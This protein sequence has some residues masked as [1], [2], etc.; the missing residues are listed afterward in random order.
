MKRIIFSF[1]A[2]LI[3]FSALW[4]QH[5]PYKIDHTTIRVGKIK[6][7]QVAQAKFVITNKSQ[8]PF[9]IKS[10]LGSCG[11]VKIYYSHKPILPGQSDTIYVSFRPYMPGKFVKGAII[12]LNLKPPHNKIYLKI[13]GKAIV[14]N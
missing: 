5:R 6:T 14:D 13:K 10:A 1:L 7:Y 9:A 2:I 4:A 12:E 8:K 3:S 11:C